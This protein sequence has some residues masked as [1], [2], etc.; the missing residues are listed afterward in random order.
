MKQMAH[1][2]RQHIR[3]PL[4]FVKWR[5]QK[6]AH[7]SVYFYTFHKCASSLFS[8][9]VLRNI[10]GLRHVD[11]AK[12]FYSKGQVVNLVFEETGFIYGPIRLSAEPSLPVY[13]EFVEPLSQPDFIQDKIAIFLL[14]DPR[15]IIVSAYYSFGFTHGRS[16]VDVVRQKQDEMANDIQSKTLQE[17]ARTTATPI[18]ANFETAGNLLDACQRTVLLKYEDMIESWDHF[19][20]DLT[21]YLQIKPTVLAQIYERTRPRAT[22]DLSS[23]RRSGKVSGFRDKL[24]SETIQFLNDTLK[25][26][27]MRFDYPL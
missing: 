12:Q 9:Y 4:D 27:L 8:G 23:H 10:V 18:R 5:V 7:E 22:E 15:D 26:V 2:W 20:T 16:R 14:R 13:T 19:A 6:N 17:Y 1:A 3:H 21:R 25:D 11:Y 24:D